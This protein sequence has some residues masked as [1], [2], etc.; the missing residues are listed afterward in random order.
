MFMSHGRDNELFSNSQW[1]AVC[2]GSR[3]YC[4]WSSVMSNKSGKLLLA[5][6]RLYISQG[7]IRQ[8]DII[9]DVMADFA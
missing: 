2:I 8:T 9:D 6:T 1:L 3:H 4:A 7:Q 5:F